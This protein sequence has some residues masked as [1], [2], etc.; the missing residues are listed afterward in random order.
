[1]LSTLHS[2][3]LCTKNIYLNRGPLSYINK[4]YFS[5]S[6]SD[7]FTPKLVVQEYIFYRKNLSPQRH[8]KH[9]QTFIALWFYRE[10]KNVI[11]KQKTKTFFPVTGH[12]LLYTFNLEIALPVFQGYKF[13]TRQTCS[14]MQQIT[15]IKITFAFS[16]FQL[17]SFHF[18]FFHK[19]YQI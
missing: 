1:M 12:Y 6:V 5:I 11:V 15:K 4:L 10:K 8:P 9:I 18:N 3:T 19:C 14:A 17:N 7:F 13:I 16:W 2:S